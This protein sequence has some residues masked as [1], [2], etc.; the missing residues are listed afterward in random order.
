MDGGSVR[1][2]KRVRVAVQCGY[3]HEEKL[4]GGI[5]FDESDAKT[6]RL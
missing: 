3:K 1:E 4:R 2:R 5:L 6:I